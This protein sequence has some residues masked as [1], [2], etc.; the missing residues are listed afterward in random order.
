MT[1]WEYKVLSRSRGV[2]RNGHY[3]DAKDWDPDVTMDD[4]NALGLEGWELVA[5]SNLSNFGGYISSNPIR[6]DDMPNWVMEVGGP[7]VAGVTT[8]QVFYFKRPKPV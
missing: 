4:F 6:T 8:R 2:T 5:V 3:M 7:V 1:Q